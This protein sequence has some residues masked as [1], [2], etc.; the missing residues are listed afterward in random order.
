MTDSNI[1]AQKTITLKA[2]ALSCKLFN[3]A[4][5]VKL[6]AFAAE[7]RRVLEGIENAANGRPE[8]EKFIDHSTPTPHNWIEMPDST[9]N[10]LEQ[11]AKELEAI[12]NAF[13]STVY[14]LARD[15]D[16]SGRA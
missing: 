12:N 11:V 2:D 10:V 9:G 5:I 6:A 1:Q 4:E 15:A 8:I 14:K 16:K 13:V 3:L 7:S